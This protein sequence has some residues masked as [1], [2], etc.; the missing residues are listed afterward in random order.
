M[1]LQLHGEVALKKQSTAALRKGIRT[2]QKRI[3]EHEDKLRH[4]ER[5]DSDWPTYIE[6]HQ[7]GLLAHWKKEIDNF[8]ESIENRITELKERGEY[9]GTDK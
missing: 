2:F 5:Y 7:R 9:E 6:S 1:N 3:A 8:K 4:P